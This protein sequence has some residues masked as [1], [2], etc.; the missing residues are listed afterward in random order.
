MK[1]KCRLKRTQDSCWK[2]QLVV[3]HERIKYLDISGDWTQP[4]CDLELFYLHVQTVADNKITVHPHR[5][6]KMCVLFCFFMQGAD[7]PRTMANIW[8]AFFSLCWEIFRLLRVFREVWV[9]PLRRATTGAGFPWASLAGSPFV[10]VL[11]PSSGG[12]G[13]VD[14][15]LALALVDIRSWWLVAGVSPRVCCGCGS[16]CLWLP[17]L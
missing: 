16:C 5:Q 15:G 9:L 1:N 7:L 11:W 14:V 12:V 3:S 8:V 6:W 2:R 13:G 17:P 10:S 4:P